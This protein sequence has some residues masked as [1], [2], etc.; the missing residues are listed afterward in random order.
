MST[1]IN[2]NQIVVGALRWM[3]IVVSVSYHSCAFNLW[4]YGCFPPFLH[5]PM[6]ILIVHVS[7]RYEIFFVR[8]VRGLYCILTVY[9]RIQSYFADCT[10]RIFSSIIHTTQLNS[11]RIHFS[12]HFIYSNSGI[13]VKSVVL[14]NSQ[15]F[16][17]SVNTL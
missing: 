3:Q 8:Q 11:E 5:Q 12:N 9:I 1:I 16:L 14:V 4:F 7:L 13:T 15:G 17:C 10:R 2:N 6:S